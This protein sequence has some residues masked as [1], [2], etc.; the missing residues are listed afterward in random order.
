MRHTKDVT[1]DATW[2]EVAL[3]EGWTD[4]LPVCMPTEAAVDAVLER[5]GR[6]PAEVVAVLPPSQ[7][8]AT[9]EQI[10]V[11]SIMAGADAGLIPLVIAAVEAVTDPVFQLP[12]AAITTNGAA[13]LVVVAGPAVRQLGFNDAEAS[14]GGQS[15]ATAALGRALRLVLRNVGGA[16]PGR[17]SMVTHASPAW[18]SYCVA[19][20]VP[21]SPWGWRHEDLGYAPDATT[22]TVFGCQAPSA[23]YLPGSAERVLAVT[24]ASMATPGVN[25]YFAG[26]EVLVALSPR[27]A[28]T[29]AAAGHTR[30]SVSEKLW[31]TSQYR[32]GDL[33]SR[34]FLGEEQHTLY[35]GARV[36]APRLCDMADDRWLPMVDS[37]D[38]IHVIVTGGVGQF[39]AAF[40]AGWGEFGGLAVTR[41]VALLSD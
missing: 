11:N 18:Y 16:V 5:L 31:E 41:E 14:F 6:D 37:A 27:V 15:R 13:P 2:Y 10:V 19:E 33:R 26:G 24:G 22:V 38:D 9:V 17:M 40:C 30:R 7:G 29:L 35:W 21:D 1:D 36:D 23:L 4:G 34:G 12:A 20:N 25:A 32:V 8:K 39:W 28:H 3:A